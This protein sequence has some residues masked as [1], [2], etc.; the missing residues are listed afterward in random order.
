MKKRYR[1]IDSR[2]PLSALQQRIKYAR[3]RS[4]SI[5]FVENVPVWPEDSFS[6]PSASP[7]DMLEYANSNG[8]D[9]LISAICERDNSLYGANIQPQNVLVTNGAMYALSLV[10]RSVYQ[11]DQVEALCVAPVFTAVSSLLTDAGYIVKFFDANAVTQCTPESILS[12]RS[13]ATRLIYLNVPHNPYG[14]VYCD[15]FIRALVTEVN[16]NNIFLVLD[17]VYDSYIFNKTLLLSPFRCTSEWSNIYTINSVSKNFGAPGLRIG[18]IS[19]S[20]NNIERAS[21]LLERECV[22][23]CTPS[24]TKAAQLIR[25]GNSPLIDSLR[26]TRELA[27]E[28]LAAEGLVDS[29]PDAGTQIF[30]ELPVTDVEDYADFALYYYGLVLATSSNYACARPGAIRVPTSYPYEQTSRAIDTLLRSLNDY[31]QQIK[32]A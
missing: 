22:S 7:V 32:H 26:K 11:Q 21:S 25:H 5:Y 8:T 28:R 12:H 3:T 6:A 13:P 18:W 17:L 23:V 16:R 15:E 9:S 14:V 10:F 4:D 30:V 24:Q 20:A 29:I 1:I 27:L 2:N 31:R 19:S